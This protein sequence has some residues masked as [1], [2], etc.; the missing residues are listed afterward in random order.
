MWVRTR[1]NSGT[2][3]REIRQ[4]GIR[5]YYTGLVVLERANS[6]IDGIGVSW[7]RYVQHRGIGCVPTY[8]ILVITK[9]NE[10]QLKNYI[11]ELNDIEGTIKF[12]HEFEQ[13]K[14]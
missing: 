8:N 13:N 4:S 5:R 11:N 2:E 10:Q 9:M 14:E 3:F 1:N 6:G 12:T 7:F